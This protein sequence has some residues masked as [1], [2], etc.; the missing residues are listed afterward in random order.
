MILYDETLSALSASL[1]SWRLGGTADTLDG[2]SAIQRDLGSW[3]DRPRGIL[4]SLTK[5]SAKSCTCWV[6][7]PHITRGWGPADWKV[8]LQK[9]TWESWWRPAWMWASNVPLWLWW[10]TVSWTALGEALPAGRGGWLFPLSQYWW[11][12]SGLLDPVLEFPGQER[13]GFTGAN[14]AKSHK[15]GKRTGACHVRS[16]WMLEER[17]LREILSMYLNS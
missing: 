14:P 7:S 12:T 13:Y 1:Q 11:D 6:M 17:R 5:W 3:R 9:R 15:D 2:C 10:P 16:G 4:W 8:I